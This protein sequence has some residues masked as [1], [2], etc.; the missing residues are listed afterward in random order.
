MGTNCNSPRLS[1]EVAPPRPLGKVPTP[2]SGALTSVCRSEI[3]GA[4]ERSPAPGTSR[5]S[6]QDRALAGSRR[7]TLGPAELG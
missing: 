6:S 4:L 3:L 2:V 1:L 5:S 7:R